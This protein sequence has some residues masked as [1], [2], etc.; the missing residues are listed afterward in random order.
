MLK[1]ENQY[2]LSKFCYHTNFTSHCH[3]FSHAY[4]GGFSS[5]KIQLRNPFVG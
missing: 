1:V 4:V 2:K 5:L 3:H